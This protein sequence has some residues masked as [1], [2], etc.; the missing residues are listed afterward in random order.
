MADIDSN[1]HAGNTVK[2]ILIW[3]E[4]CSLAVEAP[5]NR[6]VRSLEFNPL[7]HTGPL[8]VFLTL[9][10]IVTGVYLTMFYPFGFEASYRAVGNI[11]SNLIGRVVRALH[12]YASDG[13]LVVALL[14]GWRTFFMDRFRGPRW[15]AWLSGVGMTGLVWLAGVTGYWLVMD[16]RARLVERYAGAAG[17]RL[18]GGGQPSWCA[19]SRRLRVT[20]AGFSS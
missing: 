15:L 12:R 20:P 13:L 8:A 5:V 14:H 2:R 4:R 11:E 18:A 1:A 3:L 17:W 6:W 9:V 19:R 16:Q 10:I 7:Y